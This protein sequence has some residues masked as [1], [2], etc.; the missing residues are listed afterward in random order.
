MCSFRGLTDWALSISSS[1]WSG[2]RSRS[3]SLS[4]SV[5]VTE[6]WHRCL[7]NLSLSFTDALSFV[8]LLLSSVR[9][10]FW[11]SALRSVPMLSASVRCLVPFWPDSSDMYSRGSTKGILQSPER[12]HK[13][14]WS[15]SW[16]SSK[17]LLRFEETFDV[18]GFEEVALCLKFVLAALTRAMTSCRRHSFSATTRVDVWHPK[19]NFMLHITLSTQ[20]YE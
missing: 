18:E 2:T 20:L 1:M 8:V 9:L 15:T 17:Q 6:L 11:F 14:S 10:W 19:A 13:E 7:L 5:T 3:E 12:S 4:S 16:Q